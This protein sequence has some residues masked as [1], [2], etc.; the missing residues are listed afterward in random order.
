MPILFNMI[1]NDL[2]K[3]VST[4]VTVFAVH[5]KLFELVKAKAEWEKWEKDVTKQD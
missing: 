3:G 1:V 5:I 2:G 4:Q